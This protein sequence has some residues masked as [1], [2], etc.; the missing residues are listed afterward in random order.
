MLGLFPI[1]GRADALEVV[2]CQ[3][4]WLHQFQFAGYYAALEKGFYRAAGLDVRLHEGGSGR[5]PVDDVLAGRAQ[6]GSANSEVLF[7]RLKGQPLVALAAIFQHSPSVLLVRAD[8]GIRTPH[9]L[10]GKTV[11]LMGGRQDSD[12]SAMFVREG[13][14]PHTV[15]IVPTSYDLQDLVSGKVDAFNSYLSNEPF[16]LT[17]Q[18]VAFE[19]ISPA[20][21]GVDYYGDIV[22]TSE[23][24]LN[25]HPAR[26]EAFRRATLQG[27][28]YAMDH[29]DEIIDLLIDKY[30]V[31]KSREHLRFE[32]EAMRAMILPDIVD[33]GHMNAGRWQSMAM[34]FKAVGMVDQLPSL[35]G[36]IYDP[37]PRLWEGRLRR[38]VMGFTSVLVFVLSLLGVMFVWQRRLR[39]EIALR[40]ETER[41]LSRSHALLERTG[42]LASVG[43]WENDFLN[44]RCIWSDEAARIREIEPGTSMT[45]EEAIAFYEPEA[46]EVVRA[47]NRAAIEQGTPWDYELPMITRRGRHIWVRNRGEAI[48]HDGRTVL[49]TGAMQDIT[50]RKLAELSLLRRSRELEMHNSILRQIHHFAPLDEMLDSMA[51][52]IETL[53]PDFLCSILLLDAD[54]RRLRHVAAPSLPA[55]Y[56]EALDRIAIGDG[57]GCCGMAAGRGERVLAV[58]LQT[59]PLWAGCRE[60]VARAGLRSCWAEPIRNH[61]GE[62]LGTLAIYQRQ[63]GRPSVEA[64]ET[65]EN[66][67]NL[68]ELVIARHR[69]EAQIRSLAYYDVLTQLPNRRTLDDRLGQA[70]ALSKRSGRYG[71]LMFV[72][73]DNFKPLN[74]RHGHAVGDQLLIQVAQR[75][76]ACVREMDTVARFGGDEFVIVVG[77]LDERRDAS[78]AQALVVAEK[79]RDSIAD[80]FHLSAK[81]E[82]PIG[83]CCTASIGV[84]LFLNH[85]A[86]L[87]EILK[88][89]DEAMYR[90]KDLGRDRVCLIG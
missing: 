56:T 40:S 22:F 18:G 80:I 10:V 35:E 59:H 21:Y 75:V 32:A 61:Q 60:L 43:G 34:A 76:L 50:E 74:D 42:R 41:K 36:F 84:V 86:T 88:R 68:A 11:M 72:D 58:D 70:M 54:G 27:W 16:L 19:V 31:E 53:A 81:D 8:S 65:I 89:A 12:F 46:R 14:S 55:F 3:L 52:Q 62:M 67:A 77:E 82:A 9:D 63:P 33:I 28:R 30:G 57:V 45:G 87:D 69:S 26:V 78:A 49:L 1:V 83:H 90:A 2:D 37:N 23:K 4:R 6:Y 44:D 29:P 47:A 64:M 39:R 17:Q 24:E 73:L 79:I 51:R 48:I 13:V 85:E 25:E 71:A 20:T 5:L 38:V 15:N 66:F 7:Q